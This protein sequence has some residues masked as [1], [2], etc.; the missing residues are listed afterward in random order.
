MKTAAPGSVKQDSMLT[1]EARINTALTGLGIDKK[2]NP[3]GASSFTL[4]VDRRVRAESAAKGGKDLTADEK[5]RIVDTVSMDKVYV[6]EWG[7]DPEKPIFQLGDDD[8]KNAYVR[9]P[10]RKDIYG[11]Q[12]YEN[13]YL[14]TIPSTDRMQII[15]AL[16]KR[17]MPVTEQA[18]AAIYVTTKKG[19]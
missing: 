13:V 3:E 8:L 14:N 4:E 16:K 7:R 15:S 19:K 17:G 2:K 12:K 18:I 10:T 9:L 6:D 11:N 1:D 5:Q